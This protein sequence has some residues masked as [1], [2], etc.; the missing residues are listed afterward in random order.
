MGILMEFYTRITNINI[1]SISGNIIRS[2]KGCNKITFKVIK[3]ESKSTETPHFTLLFCFHQLSYNDK[4]TP[5]TLL[6]PLNSL[7]NTQDGE[8]ERKNK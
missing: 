8:R 6:H 1:F 3:G 5:Y 4:T 7:G 2:Y